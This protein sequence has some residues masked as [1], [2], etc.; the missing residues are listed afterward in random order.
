MIFDIVGINYFV[1]KNVFTGSKEQFN[2][3]IAPVEDILEVATWYGMLCYQKSDIL[4]RNTF[5]LNQQG[6][7]ACIAWLEEQYHIYKIQGTEI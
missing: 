3:R 5:E 7:D 6:L 2:F 4:A 1:S